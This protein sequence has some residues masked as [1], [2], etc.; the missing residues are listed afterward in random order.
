MGM[1]LMHFLSD[2]TETFSNLMEK[3]YPFTFMLCTMGYLLTMLGDLVVAWVNGK[4][5]KKIEVIPVQTPLPV[6]RIGE[7]V[8]FVLVVLEIFCPLLGAVG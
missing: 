4:R 6:H 1:A 2:S 7:S 5:T 8:I 3:E